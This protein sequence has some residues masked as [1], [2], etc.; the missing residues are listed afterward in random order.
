[1]LQTIIAF[2]LLAAVCAFAY[3]VV[4]SYRAGAGTFWDRLYAST[5]NSATLFVQAF[6]AALVALGNAVLNIADVLAG[7]DMRAFV[8][9]NF[10]PQFASG[11]IVALVLLNAAARLR[12]LRS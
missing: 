6:I 7:P 11:L 2:A 3:R 8:E 12:T 1:M 10:T 5:K 9:A 4:V